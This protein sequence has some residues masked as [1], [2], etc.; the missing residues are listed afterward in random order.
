MRRASFSFPTELADS[1]YM[2]ET[3]DGQEAIDK[4]WRHTENTRR[5][6]MSLGVHSAFEIN[7]VAASG[8]PIR[9][10][11]WP[12]KQHQNINFVYIADLRLD[13]QEALNTVY[14]HKQLMISSVLDLYTS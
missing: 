6:G 5:L 14:V 9:N 13:A 2:F 3:Y 4:S 10:T 7:Q 8:A 12:S 1:M 11:I